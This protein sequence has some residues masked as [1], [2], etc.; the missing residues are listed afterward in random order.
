MECPN[1]RQLA[2]LNETGNEYFIGRSSDGIPFF[3]CEECGTLFYL[4]EID[5]TAHIVP[6]VEK[7]YRLVPIIWGIVAWFIAGAIFWILGSN[8]ITWVIGVVLLLCGWF[9]IRIG[10]FGSQKLIDEMVLDYKIPLS[11][12][13]KEELRKTQK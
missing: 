13:V 2:N 6:R 10:L 7:G 5:N 8:I 1:C 11:K 3:K 4:D 12:P 9:S